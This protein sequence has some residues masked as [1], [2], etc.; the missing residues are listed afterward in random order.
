MKLFSKILI[1]AN[2]VACL[3]GLIFRATLWWV[4]PVAPNEPYGLGDV[5]ELAIYFLILAIAAFSL[6]WALALFVIPAIRDLKLGVILFVVS[7]GSPVA[8]YFLHTLVPKL[9]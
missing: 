9:V 8:Y 3:F 6:L 2:V 7:V 5:I 4:I 1:G